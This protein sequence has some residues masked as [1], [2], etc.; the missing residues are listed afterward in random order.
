MRKKKILKILGWVILF[1]FMLT[2]WGWKKDNKPVIFIG[3]FLS[4]IFLLIG[5]SSSD[6]SLLND[7]IVTYFEEKNYEEVIAEFEEAGFMNIKTKQMD[8]LITGWLTKEGEVDSVLIDGN[9]DYSTDE[10]YSND[11]E[12]IITYHTFSEEVIDIQKNSKNDK[13]DEKIQDKEGE[14]TT[15]N[16]NTVSSENEIIKKES[17]YEKAYRV[18]FQEYDICYLIDED[19]KEISI[20]S[21]SEK[22]TDVYT[23]KYEGDFNEG[24][25]FDWDGL[26]MRAHYRFVDADSTMIFH[27]EYGNENKAWKFGVHQIE[28]YITPYPEDTK[29]VVSDENKEQD[30]VNESPNIRNISGYDLKTNKKFVWG[31]IEF[32]IPSYFD[33]LQNE[34]GKTSRKYYPSEEN[35]YAS[36][37]FDIQVYTETR[38]YFTNNFDANINEILNGKE[39]ANAK[40]MN[41]ESIKISDLPGW[42]VSLNLYENDNIVS[43]GIITFIYNI[44]IEK[45]IIISCFFDSIDDSQYDYLGDYNKILENIKL[46][47]NKIVA[48]SIDLNAIN[49]TN[50][51][52]AD[53]QFLGKYYILSG[54]IYEA[55]GGD[56][57]LIR[58]WPETMAK[59]MNLRVPLELNIWMSDNGFNEIG[60]ESSLEKNVEI[61][62]ELISIRRN[63]ENPS[64]KGYPIELEF[65]EINR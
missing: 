3:V 18:R 25:T 54:E 36:L 57:P 64:I 22:Y 40:I 38:D 8:D 37:S 20:F 50:S 6:D 53:S 51:A 52:E 21:T 7:E 49:N 44:D 13:I 35:Y 30:E 61:V 59:G 29:N 9:E 16:N 27:D 60:G 39:F 15:Q 23:S 48:E 41:S 2:Y 45:I 4:I 47:E 24:I 31:E 1:P 26:K 19:K 33:L 14:T 43:K 11:V 42:T 17:R 62:A 58:I 55:M 28:S 56:D 65:R 12:V 5:G 46:Q 34:S 10:K 32:S 63:T